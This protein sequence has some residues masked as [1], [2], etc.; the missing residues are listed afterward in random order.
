M[1]TSLIFALACSALAIIYGIA[2]CKWILSQP[3]GTDRM[4]EI[5]AAIEEGASAYLKRQY[6]I[7]SLV[8]ILLFLIIGFIPKLGWPTAIAFA[9]GAIFSAVA[10][11]IGMSIS[12][13]ANVRTTE[14]ARA[15]GLAA[16]LNIAFRGG[17]I[18]GL[19]VVGLALLGVAGFF[20]LMLVLSSDGERVIDGYK[21]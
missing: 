18:T 4:R 13:R 20:A 16:A 3:T 7:I 8:G 15:S 10:G 21:H 11:A 9:I 19:L 12:V 5:A 14:A 2:L 1:P 6:S 17:A